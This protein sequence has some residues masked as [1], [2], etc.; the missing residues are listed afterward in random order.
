MIDLK[1]LDRIT[2]FNGFTRN[3]NYDNIAYI[4]NILTPLRN[5]LAFK[6]DTNTCFRRFEMKEK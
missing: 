4:K 3:Y 6:N 2:S 5:I 1:R